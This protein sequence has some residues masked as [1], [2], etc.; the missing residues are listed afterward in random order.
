[1]RRLKN[2][3][4]Y[5]ALVM[6]VSLMLALTGCGGTTGSS[7]VS[8][9]VSHYEKTGYST[10]TVKQGDLESSIS[11]VLKVEDFEKINYSSSEEGLE[12]DTLYV[13]AGDKVKAGDVLVSFKSDELQHTIDTYE[14]QNEQNQLL[15][16]HYT[17]LMN[18]DSSNDYTQDIEMLKEDISVAQLY[19]EEAKERLEN[20]SIVAK[21]SGTITYVSDYLESGHI[22]TDS[23]MITEACGSENYTAQTSDSYELNVGD[24]YTAGSGVALYDMKLIEIEDGTDSAGNFLRTLRFEPVSDMSAVSEQDLLTMEIEKPTLKN[25]VYV[26]SNAVH[27]SSGNYF[28]YVLDEDGYRDAVIVTVD[29]VVD[30]YTIIK[31]GLSGGEQVTLN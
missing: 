21:R 10:V 27:V 7:V 1:M 26:D 22:V 14:E 4:I 20:Y 3:K 25:V 6:A 19:I 8:I 24:V 12:I 17:R 5:P 18:I 29:D 13:S 15:I 11:L 16:D 31:D 28:V 23:T 9:P 2:K 30:G